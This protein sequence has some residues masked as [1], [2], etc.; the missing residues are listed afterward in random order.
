MQHE[1]L[2]G[3]L[4]LALILICTSWCCHILLLSFL[5]LLSKCTLLGGSH[6]QISITKYSFLT[7]HSCRLLRDTISVYLSWL[8]STGPLVITQGIIAE[9]NV[10]AIVLA[11]I[12]G[13]F[14]FFARLFVWA[15]H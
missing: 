12:D 10:M 1:S 2:H 8:R 14:G 3:H 11:V 4:V 13:Q 7:Y 9:K 15:A 5:L 6:H